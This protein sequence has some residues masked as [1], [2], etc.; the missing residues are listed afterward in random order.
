M[1]IYEYQSVDPDQGCQKCS[2]RFEVIQQMN[3]EPLDECPHCGCK[4]RR[5][6]SWCRANVVESSEEYS[7]MESQVR[8]YEQQGMWSHAAEL[9]DS[10]AEKAKDSQLKT[11][12]LDNYKKAGYD[13]D[14]TT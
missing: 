12:A 6:I 1:P 2:T 5:L 11:R 4:V 7:R 13:V 14:S 10:H 9:A 3:D 8:E